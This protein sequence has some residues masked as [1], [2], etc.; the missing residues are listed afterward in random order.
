MSRRELIRAADIEHEHVRVVSRLLCVPEAQPTRE[1]ILRDHAEEVHGVFGLA[2]RRCVGEIEVDEIRCAQAGAHRRGEHVD[3]LVDALAS[4]GLRAQDRSVVV[5]V[6]HEVHRRGTGEVARVLVGVQ[7]HGAEGHT[8]GHEVV[9]VRPGRRHGELADAHDRCPERRWDGAGARGAEDVVGDEP[10]GAVGGAGEG[11]GA[12]DP[13]GRIDGEGRVARGPHPRGG[14]AAALVHDDRPALGGDAGIRDEGGVGSDADREDH[15]IRYELAAVGEG[16]RRLNAVVADRCRRD[17]RVD[18][19]AEVL[20]LVGGDLCE[21]A[22]DAGEGMGREF[23]DVYLE[24][25][26]AQRL[27]GFDADVARAEHHG[28]ASAVVDLGAEVDGVGHRAERSYSRR[29]DAGERR[30]HRRR[31]RSEHECVVVEGLGAVRCQGGDGLRRGVDR[32]D[33]VSRA[34]V[35]VQGGTEGVGSVQAQV[36][37]RVDLGTHVI[38]QSAV[39]E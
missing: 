30:S 22:L 37:R 32:D 26:V 34:H 3:A 15:D 39:G 16:H 38:G 18:T 10:P 5:D 17:P 23:D 2:V 31:A 25:A 8:G 13:Q 11:D 20:E 19:D 29:V 27:G 1:Q 6:D 4:R 12:A 14:S 24:P 36:L 7:V 21:L 9:A 33:L 28:A 35:E